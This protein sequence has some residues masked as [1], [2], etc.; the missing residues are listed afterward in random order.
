MA[1][2]KSAK[3]SPK[4]PTSSLEVAAKPVAPAAANTNDV[5]LALKEATQTYASSL[6]LLCPKSAHAALESK[7]EHVRANAVLA[8]EGR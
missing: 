7:L 3:K 5:I 1:A 4:V 8:I 6:R 2:K